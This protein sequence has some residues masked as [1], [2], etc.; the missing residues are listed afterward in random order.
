MAEA[1]YPKFSP[2]GNTLSSAGLPGSQL[3]P[4]V[5][6]C[7]VPTPHSQSLTCYKDLH[8]LHG[9][10]TCLKGPYQLLW[11]PLYLLRY[12]LHGGLHY[13]P[14]GPYYPPRSPT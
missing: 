6:S 5:P 9:T 2:G 14:K 7:N 4:Q 10:S 3:E 11:V 1:C 8:L 12:M 13:Y